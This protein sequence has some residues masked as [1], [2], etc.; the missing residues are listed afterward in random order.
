MLV[1]VLIVIEEVFNG[2][3]L[4]ADLEDLYSRAEALKDVAQEEP[5][6]EPIVIQLKYGTWRAA[7]LNVWRAHMA[8]VQR[9]ASP[10]AHIRRP[11]SS[12]L[13]QPPAS[14]SVQQRAH[15][16]LQVLG[17][18]AT[19]VS[20]EGVS[21]WSMH[22]GRGV[23]RHGGGHIVLRHL[24][25]LI[26]QPEGSRGMSFQGAEDESDEEERQM[27][28]VLWQL[29][30]TQEERDTAVGKLERFIQAWDTLETTFVDAPTTCEEWCD[31]M[32]K[33][34]QVLKSMPGMVPRLPRPASH[35]S[36]E[37][38]KYTSLWTFRGSM[39]L[40]MHQAGIK[41]LKVG[42]IALKKFCR[43]NPD[44]KE[45]LIRVFNANRATIRTTKDLL[46]HCGV[47]RPELLSMELCLTSDRG[48]DRVNFEEMDVQAWRR[49]KEHL[50][51]RHGM[52]PHIVCIAKRVQQQEGGES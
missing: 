9:P 30:R 21:Y 34:I 49:A 25:V 16:L 33:A 20:K 22:A 28:S 45:H 10:T 5:A 51:V 8:R 23:S 43:M 52:S 1:H 3:E 2:G 6:M 11:A 14:S 29:A 36:D 37:K 44:E 4:P 46:Q 35:S 39:L 12:S 48:L 27:S 31:Q 40:R 47:Q 17:Q 41:K 13:V 19:E 24:G 50:R 15:S 18:A 32:A 38:D 7:V 26:A 42:D